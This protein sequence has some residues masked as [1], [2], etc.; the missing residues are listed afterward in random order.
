VVVA[1]LGHSRDR[2]GGGGRSTLRMGERSTGTATSTGNV[3]LA[4]A[5]LAA[6]ATVT[7]TG[8]VAG[9]PGAPMRSYPSP[10]A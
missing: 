7:F 5:T 3:V 2:E 10:W 9:P 1:R 4:K 8:R 6:K